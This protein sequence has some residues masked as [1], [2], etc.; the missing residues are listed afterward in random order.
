MHMNLLE[1][2]EFDTKI[3]W[4]SELFELMEQ[5]NTDGHKTDRP[6]NVWI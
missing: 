5:T 6:K 1:L 2:Q 3:H 4:I